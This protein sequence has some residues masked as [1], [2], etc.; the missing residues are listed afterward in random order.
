MLIVEY[1]AP[2]ATVAATAS[3]DG[4]DMEWKS[5]NEDFAE[6]LNENIPEMDVSTPFL[7]KGVEGVALQG[8][9]LVFGDEL[10]VVLFEPKPTPDEEEGV[11]D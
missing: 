5:D 10:V 4:E 7:E 6:A 8:A 9:K 2:S 3:W 1:K 11:C